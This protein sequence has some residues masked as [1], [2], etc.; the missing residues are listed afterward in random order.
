MP[1]PCHRLS[2]G[3]R[4]VSAC[5]A[6]FPFRAHFEPFQGL[7]AGFPG[8]GSFQGGA[9]EALGPSVVPSRPCPCRQAGPGLA[10]SISFLF[11]PRAAISFQNG[12]QKF[13]FV[14]KS[15]KKFP[16]FGTYQW[17]TRDS[18][19]KSNSQAAHWSQDPSK[20]KPSSRAPKGAWRSRGRRALNIPLDRHVPPDQV[21]G[22]LAMTD[23]GAGTRRPHRTRELGPLPFPSVSF[24]GLQFPSKT[25]SKNF[26]GLQKF[27]KNFR[28]SGLINGLRATLAEKNS[29]AA[30]FGRCGVGPGR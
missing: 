16:R 15:C 23:R 17:V 26:H 19:R 8:G 30:D 9:P 3:P 7:A 20:P 14:A 24:Q 13:Q 22:F 6:A 4:A 10:I 5:R 18:G 2:T 25:A 1:G 28:D 12:F 29:Q 21:R 27:A 11:F